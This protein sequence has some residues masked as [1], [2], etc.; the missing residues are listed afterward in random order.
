MSTYLIVALI[1]LVRSVL[2]VHGWV[3]YL[4]SYLSGHNYLSKLMVLKVVAYLNSFII[5]PYQ[6]H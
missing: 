4:Q 5:L 1:L 6:V 2:A 3:G